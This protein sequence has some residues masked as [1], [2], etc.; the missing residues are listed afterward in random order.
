M[1]KLFLLVGASLL[2]TSPVNAQCAG[3]DADFN[4]KDREA[5][6]REEK[7]AKDRADKERLKDFV[8][9]TGTAGDTID[10]MESNNKAKDKAAEDAGNP[11]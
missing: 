3:C 2:L 11:N 7:A 10:K 8:G 1:K 9:R 6:A 4:K 5:V